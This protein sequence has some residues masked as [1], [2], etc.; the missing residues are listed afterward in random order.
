ATA[1]WNLPKSKSLLARP[2]SSWLRRVRAFRSPT[3]DCLIAQPTRLGKTKPDRIPASDAKNESL[4]ASA[5]LYSSNYEVIGTVRALRGLGL[6]VGL[7]RRSRHSARS[8]ADLRCIP[9]VRMPDNQKP[10]SGSA[11]SWE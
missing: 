2:S 9:E 10:R 5:A 11:L 4:W 3:R 6:F 8:Q 7:G 1:T